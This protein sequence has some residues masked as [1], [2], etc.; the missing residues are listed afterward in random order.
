MDENFLLSEIKQALSSLEDK[1]EIVLCSSTPEVAAKAILEAVVGFVPNAE[2]SVSE[3]SG[4]RS[5]V[6]HAVKDEKFFD[7]EM[8][9]LTGLTAD[10]F[11]SAAEKLPKG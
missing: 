8:P 3:M 2:L 1:G 5:L 11:R 4:L 7:W 9:T 10:E 6:F